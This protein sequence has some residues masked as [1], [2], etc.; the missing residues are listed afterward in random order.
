MH[1]L[2]VHGV[3]KERGE[4]LQPPLQRHFSCELGS[5]PT[6]PHNCASNGR[7]SARRCSFCAARAVGVAG[8]VQN[9]R[10]TQLLAAGPT[11]AGCWR[12]RSIILTPQSTV[13]MPFLKAGGQQSVCIGCRTLVHNLL[14]LCYLSRVMDNQESIQRYLLAPV[15]LL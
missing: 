12:R 15:A 6:R 1:L 5:S 11:A 7:E 9:G 13:C 3:A 4:A 2:T 14:Y 10:R 8:W